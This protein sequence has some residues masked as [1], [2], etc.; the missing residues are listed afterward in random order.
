MKKIAFAAVLFLSLNTAYGSSDLYST[1]GMYSDPQAMNAAD[2]EVIGGEALGIG[3]YWAANKVAALKSSKI[4]HQHLPK[5]S[6]KV[7]QEYAKFKPVK[8]EYDAQAE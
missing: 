7:D 8:G 1:D 3:S 5:E 2:W 6:G 4:W